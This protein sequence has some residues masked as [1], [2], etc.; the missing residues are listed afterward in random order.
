M[1]ER[2]QVQ[3]EQATQVAQAGQATPTGEAVQIARS[4]VMQQAAATTETG[5]R[6]H[7]AGTAAG[8]QLGV[9]SQSGLGGQSGV[10]AVLD[11]IRILGASLLLAFFIVNFVGRAFTVEGP[12]MI[13]TLHSG[14]RLIVDEL[15]YRFGSPERGDVIV[16]R[17]PS[18]PG[19]FFVKR[20]VALPGE[21]V[22]IHDGRV[23]VNGRPLIEDY[24]PTETPG[25]FGPVIVP[26][27]HYF[28]L[29]DN[30]GNS[31][32]SRDPRVGFVPRRLVVGRAIWRY[33]PL[34]RVSVLRPPAEW[35]V[36]A[37]P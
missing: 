13:P 18:N 17:Y 19:E 36:L 25:E 24:L 23:W 12:S 32:D 3:A 29:G 21:E 35:Q 9:S 20:L 8:N 26:E 11:V 33:W 6:A 31:A 22:A 30:R 15:S 7:P 27:D 16:F 2:L 4:E 10:S 5:V 34:D 1:A 37:R 14:E 28:V